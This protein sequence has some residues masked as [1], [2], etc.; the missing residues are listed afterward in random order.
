MLF[1]SAKTIKKD[2][3]ISRSCLR[4]WAIDGKVEYRQLP[5]GKRLYN[6]ND[7]QQ[8]LG[9]AEQEK[10]KYIYARV[11]SSHQKEDLKRQIDDLQK[12]YPSHRVISDIGSGLNFH[13]KGLQALLDSVFRR[14]VEEVVV[15][16]KD[17]LC[18]FG[19]ELFETIFERHNARIVVVHSSTDAS[20]S[21]ELA[22]DLF[23]VVNFF[24]ARNN[25]TRAATNR[26][27]RRSEGNQD[28]I[29]AEHVSEDHL[30]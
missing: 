15:A 29:E 17:R 20:P 21:A 7:I 19:F 12:E 26:K 1:V 30:S 8:L 13:R 22:E 3:D 4:Q 24:V 16:H 14:D 2:Y 28:Q 27:R 11:S 10:E 6:T 18:R 23:A 25:G 9:E 5:G